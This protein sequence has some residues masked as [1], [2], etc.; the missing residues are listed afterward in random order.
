MIKR[1]IIK[2]IDKRLSELKYFKKQALKKG[3]ISVR[4]RQQILTE[5]TY[6]ILE[7]T[8]LREEISHLI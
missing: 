8:N 5:V 2:M 3:L 7:F 6:A 4:T 1:K